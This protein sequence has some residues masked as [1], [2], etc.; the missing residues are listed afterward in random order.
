M[1]YHTALALCTVALL[2][3]CSDDK[4]SNALFEKTINQSGQNSVCLP[5]ILNMQNPRTPGLFTQLPLGLTEI[6]IADQDFK[7]RSIN[8][9]AIKQLDILSN[10][11]FYE[12][13]KQEKTENRK[14]GGQSEIYLYRLTEKGQEQVRGKTSAPRFCIG[15]QKVVKINWYT[16][17]A[18]SNG[19]TVSRVSY[20]AE[21]VPDHWVENLLKAGGSTKLPVS[22][23]STQST[24]LIKTNEGWK[25]ERELR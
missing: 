10:E 19:M 9:T 21:F 13:L 4:P 15:H 5:L 1:K 12:K 11:G 24:A 6:K 18:P 22:K 8:K 2:S 25:D 17:P 7:G 23:I 16:E 20:D 14:N 3:A